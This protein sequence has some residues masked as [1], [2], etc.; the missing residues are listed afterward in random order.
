MAKG[1]IFH[2]PRTGR[3]KKP[4]GIS[5]QTAKGFSDEAI[6]GRC[7]SKYPIRLLNVLWA[8]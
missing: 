1:K 2:R 3:L 4:V 5:Q 8:S 7:G 6:R